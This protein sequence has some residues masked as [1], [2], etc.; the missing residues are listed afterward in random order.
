MIFYSEL[1]QEISAILGNFT[2]Q[3]G[4][5]VWG[6]G[7]QCFVWDH[8]AVAPVFGWRISLEDHQSIALPGAS[9]EKTFI[10]I[11]YFSLFYNH[12]FIITKVEVDQ[13]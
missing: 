4:L 11:Q 8:R 1:R 2:V 10:S 5:P 7:R 13:A 12:W 3:L 9:D 6:G